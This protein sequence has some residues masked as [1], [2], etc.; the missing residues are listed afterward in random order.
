MLCSMN[1]DDRFVAV[2]LAVRESL[3]VECH[4]QVPC[5]LGGAYH[6]D[7]DSKVVGWRHLCPLLRWMLLPDLTR[8]MD[9]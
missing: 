1:L 7:G 9:P 8:V 2:M 6:G 5:S 3:T 4:T